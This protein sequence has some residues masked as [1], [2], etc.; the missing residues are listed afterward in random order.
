MDGDIRTGCKTAGLLGVERGLVRPGLLAHRPGA[1]V[2][3]DECDAARRRLR[4]WRPA[5]CQNW[6]MTAGFSLA[7][8]TI[9]ILRPLPFPLAPD[10]LYRGAKSLGNRAVFGPDFGCA[11]AGTGAMLLCCVG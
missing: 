10:R 9:P 3:V 5:F 7:S 4:S 1:T 11:A 8:V 6:L 2:D